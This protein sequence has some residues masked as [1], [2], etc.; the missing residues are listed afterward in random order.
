MSAGPWEIELMY[1]HVVLVSVDTLR[2]DAIAAAPHDFLNAKYALGFRPDTPALNR[3]AETGAYFSNVLSAAPYTSTSHASYFAGCWPLRHGLYEF[4]NRRLARKTL[5]DVARHEGY[6]TIFKTDFPLIL[7][8]ELGFTD[9]VDEFFVEDDELFLHRLS[10]AEKSLSF[11]HFGGAHLPYG[12]HNLRYGGS[13][14]RAKVEELGQQIGGFGELPADQLV[15]THRDAEDLHY[16]IRYK[17]AVE[18]LYKAGAYEKLMA[19]YLDGVNFFERTRLGPFLDRLASLVDKGNALVV[20]FGDHGEEYDQNSRGH[21]DSLNE[22]VVRVPM[23]FWG[24][25][26][27]PGTWDDPIRTVDLAP[28]LYERLGWRPPYDDLDGGSL[29]ETVFGGLRPR[30][31]GAAFAQT[32]VANTADFLRLQKTMLEERKPRQPLRHVLYKE[33][34]WHRGGRL[35]Q[36]HHRH[37]NRE[38]LSGLHPCNAIVTCDEEVAPGEFAPAPER[39]K[40]LARLLSAYNR[41]RA[42]ISASR[43]DVTHVRRSLANTGYHV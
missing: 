5:F 39:Q 13:A 31:P 10:K 8:A 24:R 9:A 34:V 19:L 3:F 14:Y 2:A 43:V 40:E 42:G 17:T 22:G 30:D 16:L 38:Q 32:Y 37:G 20:I 11:V 26:V 36:Q 25:D 6:R 35:V 1:D 15:E 28:T 27:V 18:H 12:Y 7:G 23:I 33:A 41:N 29:C 4:Y 21:F